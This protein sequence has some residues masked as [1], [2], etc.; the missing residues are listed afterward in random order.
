M[1]WLVIGDWNEILATHE[2]EGGNPRPL[3]YMI[4]QRWRLTSRPQAA[5]M[6]DIDPGADG[7]KLPRLFMR[8]EGPT[9]AAPARHLVE[10][11]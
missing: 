3:Q 5:S 10:F 7:G 11:R 6:G 2:K 8:R 1:R 4:G 9:Q